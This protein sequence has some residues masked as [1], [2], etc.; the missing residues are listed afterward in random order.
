MVFICIDDHEAGSHYI[1]SFNSQITAHKTDSSE[2]SAETFS[3]INHSN[4]TAKQTYEN[5]VASEQKT[6]D[7]ICGHREN[8]QAILRGFFSLEG[9][10]LN[11]DV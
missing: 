7:L 11:N 5:T 8:I 3:L 1:R 2:V 9:G 10:D 6:R 4:T